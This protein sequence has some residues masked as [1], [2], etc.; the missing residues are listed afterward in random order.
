MTN[1]EAKTQFKI[2]YSVIS[3]YYWWFYKITGRSRKDKNV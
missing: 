2:K 3:N 1:V